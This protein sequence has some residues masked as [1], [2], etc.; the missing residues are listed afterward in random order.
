MDQPDSFSVPEL[1]PAPNPLDEGSF[2]APLN[3]AG[4]ATGNEMINKRRILA[5]LMALATWAFVSL[6]YQ[7]VSLVIASAV[8]WWLMIIASVAL[9]M[10]YRRWGP[11]FARVAQAHALLFTQ[12][13]KSL[14]VDWKVS[15]TS[16]LVIV[17]ASIALGQ[18]AAEHSSVGAPHSPRQSPEV[19]TRSAAVVLPPDLRPKIESVLN[20]DQRAMEGVTS[21][22]Q[23]VA[24][25]RAIPLDECPGD[26]QDAYLTHIHAWESLAE[27]ERKALQFKEHTSSDDAMVEAFVR[28]LLGDPWG[29]MNE[30]KHDANRLT[31][32]HQSIV[33]KIKDSYNAVERVAVRH[34]ARLPARSRQD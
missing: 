8:F 17:A 10:T 13:V 5:V 27:L 32:E 29:K 9:G 33:L 18:A 21:A 23:L 3:V 7:A 25:L 19:S 24:R 14:D 4:S 6:V 30:V 11:D 15:V 26:F 2:A 31:E 22:A 16:L 34:G 12:V 1:E 20:A 28:G